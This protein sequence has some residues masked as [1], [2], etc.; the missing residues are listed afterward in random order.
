MINAVSPTPNNNQPQATVMPTPTMM[1]PAPLMPPAPTMSTPPMQAMPP[2]MP[3]APSMPA[4]MPQAPV[5][6]MPAVKPPM[7]TFAQRPDLR[8]NKSMDTV[9]TNNGSGS[10][11]SKPSVGFDVKDSSPKKKNNLPLVAGLVA[12]FIL[13]IGGGA[14]LYL[15][16]TNNDTRN[17]ASTGVST[18]GCT[19]A[20]QSD[21]NCPAAHSCS[22]N[23]C[24]LSACLAAG[25]SCDANKC[26]VTNSAACSLN[27]IATAT[28][29]LTCQKVAYQDEL[30]NSAGNYTLKTAKSTFLPGDTVVFKVTMTNNGQTT[31]PIS[32]SDVLADAGTNN[33][34]KV[35]FLDSDCGANAYNSSTKTLSC[36]ASTVAV[37][38]SLS[39]IF[40]VKIDASTADNTTIT[41][42][43]IASIDSATTASCNAAVTVSKTTTYSCNSKC[44]TDAQCQTANASYTCDANNGNICRLDSNRNDNNCNPPV[45][46]YACN[47]SCTTNAQCQTA[48]S[49]YVCSNNYC[50]LSSNTSATNCQPSTPTPTPPA[51]GCNQTCVTNADCAAS[52]QICAQTTSGLKCRLD[53]YVNS[54][55]CTPPGTTTVVSTPQ[56]TKPVVLPKSGSTETTMRFIMMGAAAVILGGLG[57]LLL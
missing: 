23:K 49:N 2:V 6:A 11:S 41:N 12:L 39:H 25:A 4:Q 51:V 18:P 31:Y 16:Q 30:S 46:T 21:L 52:N 19:S 44:T 54:D 24:V 32:L 5:S 33:L 14:G 20:C 13:L 38:A 50:R 57:V 53:N 47:S 40:R 3:S 1:P 34:G 9:P 45:N 27:F 36:S 17:N 55:T 37:G 10:G 7:P 42:T 43:A 22:Q 8:E 35:T 28:K 15:S 48:N 26:V 56:P 29:N